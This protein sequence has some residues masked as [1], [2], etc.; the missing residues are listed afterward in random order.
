M[1]IIAFVGLPLSG[2][3]TASSVAREMGIPVVVMGDVVREEVKKRGLPLTDENAGKVANELRERE[4]MDAIAKRCIPRIRELDSDVVVVDG[5]RGIAEVDR[6]RKAFGNDFI[7]IAI[8]SPAELRLERA[9]KR[10]RE[11]DRSIKTMEDL[12]RRDEREISWGMLEAMEKANLVVENV[13]S[14]DDFRDKVRAILK[15][16]TRG[17]EVDVYTEVNPTEDVEKVKKAIEN[18]FPGIELEFDESKGI[19]RGRVERLDRFREL[20]RMQRILD[21]ARAE[22]KRGWRGKESTVFINKQAATVS[23]INFTEEKTTLSPIVVTFKA[24][25]VPFE[26]FIDWLAPETR[27]GK[28]VR[29][30]ELWD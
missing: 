23:R 15:N 27:D 28:P 21:T 4:G 16:F 14:I 19:L 2:K 25:G 10:G 20:L 13:S 7:L 30:I 9:R 29:E 12:K 1:K 22:L 3:S 24:Y 5:I 26:K 18:L 17:I 6:F 8:E 11:D